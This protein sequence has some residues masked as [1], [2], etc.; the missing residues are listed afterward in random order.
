MSY[1]HMG[2]RCG[3]GASHTNT[4]GSYSGTEI[5]AWGDSAKGGPESM[6]PICHG[7]PSA[8]GDPQVPKGSV[9]PHR[10]AEGTDVLE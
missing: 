5:V 9:R 2:L 4:D 6:F 3:R 7:L 10:T 1:F 8:T